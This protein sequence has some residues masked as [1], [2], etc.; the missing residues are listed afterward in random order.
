MAVSSRPDPLRE[1]LIDILRQ[2]NSADTRHEGVEPEQALELLEVEG[3]LEAQRIPRPKDTNVASAMGLLL[4]NKLVRVIAPGDYS[5]QR[6][7]DTKPRYQITTEGKKFLVEALENPN[8]V[9]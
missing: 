9:R 5:W 4:R 1:M 3:R 2:L 6:G 8:R 7:R